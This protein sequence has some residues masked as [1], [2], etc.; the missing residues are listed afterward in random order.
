MAEHVE[1]VLNNA[2][3]G[4]KKMID[5]DSVVGNPINISDST[6]V[7]PVSKVSMGFVSGGSSFGKAPSPG[8]F[9]G[10]A[11]GG[12]KISPV[13]FLVITD[14]N[15]RL[16]NVTDTPDQTDK[17]FTKIPELIDQISALISKKK[18]DKND[19]AQL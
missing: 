3:D 18:E 15:V 8:N 17:I 10:G 16:V 14:G 19:S 5:V 11:G 1:Q 7:I 6:T 12:I 9:G 13:A 4:L 2:I